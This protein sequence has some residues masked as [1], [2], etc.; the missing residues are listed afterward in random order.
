MT[1]RRMLRPALVCFTVMLGAGAMASCSAVEGENNRFESLAQHVADIRLDGSPEPASLAA[2]QPPM[3]PAMA[4]SRSPLKVEL[5]D[6]HDLWDA[7]DGGLRGTVGDIGERAAQV[8]APVVAQAALQRASLRHSNA[9]Q[10]RPAMPVEPVVEREAGD[11]RTLIQI[12]AYSSPE[13]ARVAWA[14]VSKGSARGALSGLSPVYEAVEVN[15]RQFTRLKIAAPA[16]SG[17]AICQAVAV[18]DPWCARHVSAS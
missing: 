11:S 17:A 1:L 10:M 15:G 4:S 18:S 12:G 9:T 3:R 6:V 5:M 13:A 2:E 16:A 14:N 7:R 8:A